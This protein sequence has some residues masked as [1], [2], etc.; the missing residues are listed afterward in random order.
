MVMEKGCMKSLRVLQMEGLSEL[1]LL[2]KGIEHLTSLHKLYL[3]EC[4]NF[5]LYAIQE[6]QRK[7]VGHI[8]N[9]WHAYHA[10][11]KKI[12][13]I[14]SRP[15]TR[16]PR[17]QEEEEEE[18]VDGKSVPPFPFPTPSETG[19]DEN[20]FSY[21]PPSEARSEMNDRGTPV[22]GRRPTGLPFRRVLRC[23][24]KN[25]NSCP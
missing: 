5:L 3:S 14:L 17:R 6:D 24:V 8:P 1:M 7:R 15:T 2:P 10:D 22:K 18:E 25:R 4:N 12:I 23:P 11:G 19:T 16:A 20:V 9:I 21:L 13:E